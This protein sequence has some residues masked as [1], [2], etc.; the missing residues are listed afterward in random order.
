MRDTEQIQAEQA[1]S[2]RLQRA[3][4]RTS[5]T[6]APDV[7]R[8]VSR[9]NAR[10]RRTRAMVATAGTA[11]SAVT[12]VAATAFVSGGL[13]TSDTVIAANVEDVPLAVSALDASVPI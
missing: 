13:G 11:L 10:R 6:W 4:A 3:D 8:A 12:L 7:D 2:Q 1:V 5:Y 9:G